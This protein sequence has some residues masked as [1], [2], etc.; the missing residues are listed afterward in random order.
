MNKKYEDVRDVRFSF[1]LN[2]LSFAETFSKEKI[3]DAELSLRDAYRISNFEKKRFIDVGCGSGLFSLAAANMGASVY[4]FDFDENSVFC[5]K[6]VRDKF[7]YKHE[8]WQID[9]GS[10]LDAKFVNQL[11]KFEFIYCWGVAHHTGDV[12]ASL[13]NL[14]SLAEKDSKLMIALYNDQG[15]VSNYW[16]AVKKIYCNYTALRPLLLF[17]HFVYPTLPFLL[18]KKILNKQIPRGMNWWHDLKD[19]VGGY[20]FEVTK[21][22]EVVDFFFSHGFY[23]TKIKTV[24]GKMG[25]NEF[26]FVKL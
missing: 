16:K 26:V 8:N 17:V 5:S 12:W 18:F 22:E 20:P 9:S 25:C 1:G 3:E 23:L 7:A 2:W 13:S 4:S 15:W 11:G 24:S 19:W 21:P 14:C 6:I 10:L